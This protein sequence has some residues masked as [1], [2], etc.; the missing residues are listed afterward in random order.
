MLD[1]IGIDFK[2]LFDT[3]GQNP[4]LLISRKVTFEHEPL[5]Y[6]IVVGECHSAHKHEVLLMTFGK[7]FELLVGLRSSQTS[8]IPAGFLRIQ[9]PTKWIKVAMAGKWYRIVFPFAFNDLHWSGCCFGRPT[10]RSSGPGKP[11]FVIRPQ[12]D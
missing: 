7:L 10:C 4:C 6:R 12:S 9:T 5:D 2:L 3:V 8:K 1:R 11:C